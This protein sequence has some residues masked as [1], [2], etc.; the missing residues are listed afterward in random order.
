[1]KLPRRTPQGLG[2]LEQQSAVDHDVLTPVPSSARQR[3]ELGPQHG[4]LYVGVTS[5]YLRQVEKEFQTVA[6]ESAVE[7]R[8]NNDLTRGTSGKYCNQI[9]WQRNRDRKSKNKLEIIQIN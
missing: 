7:L 6:N 2:E 1:M 9:H 8:H 4:A 3:P 5:A